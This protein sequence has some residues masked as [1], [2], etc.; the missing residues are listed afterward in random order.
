LEKN[1]VCPAV[2]IFNGRSGCFAE[3]FAGG[4]WHLVE[5]GVTVHGDE[6]VVTIYSTRSWRRR[7]TTEPRSCLKSWQLTGHLETNEGGCQASLVKDVPFELRRHRVPKVVGWDG[8]D[9]AGFDPMGLYRCRANRGVVNCTNK[10]GDAI[11]YRP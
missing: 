5:A 11:R 4:R 1:Y 2:E 6:Y 10:L 3:Y 9:T 7:W 8:T